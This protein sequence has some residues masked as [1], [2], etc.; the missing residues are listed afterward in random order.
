M[1][2]D[3][4]FTTINSKSKADLIILL[5]NKLALAKPVYERR[6][7]FIGNLLNKLLVADPEYIQIIG[8]ELFAISELI[9]EKIEFPVCDYQ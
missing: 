5:K 7:K 1:G 9:R 6:E 4:A 3:K 2:L 8:I